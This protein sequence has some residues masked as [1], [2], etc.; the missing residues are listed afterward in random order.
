MSITD[1][2]RICV[3]FYSFVCWMISSSGLS[4]QVTSL[5]IKFF[6][7]ETISQLFI[8]RPQLIT[9]PALDMCSQL[10]NYWVEKLNQTI[11]DFLDQTS[12]PDTVMV[13]VDY[14]KPP[15]YDYRFHFDSKIDPREV[16]EVRKYLKNKFVCYSFQL[17]PQY[18]I[19]LDYHRITN[20][21]SEPILWT[22]HINPRN[23]VGYKTAFWYIFMHSSTELANYQEGNNFI[24]VYWPTISKINK[25][26]LIPVNR[27][28]ALSYKLYQSELLPP[29][30]NTKCYNYKS[31]QSKFDSQAHCFETCYNET[32]YSVFNL[33]SS[34]IPT[35]EP[36]HHK[37]FLLWKPEY[38]LH[39]KNCSIKCPRTDCIKND[40]IPTIVSLGKSFRPQFKLYATN[41]PTIRQRTVSKID[42]T[43]Y[44]IFVLSCINFWLG[45]S[46]LEFLLKVKSFK[47]NNKTNCVNGNNNNLFQ[48]STNCSRGMNQKIQFR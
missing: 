16:I 44:I 24:E 29:P 15:N 4:Y 37:R 1:K 46:P 40:F 17:K 21:F 10:R 23:F 27:I 32:I 3:L 14:R 7:Y 38:R 36:T 45:L 47:K 31:N 34:T 5:S 12:P 9:P 30:F 26:V 41:T 48:Q 11:K 35:F 8:A 2:K 18:A 25:T 43:E 39:E 33:V 6:K 22:I 28:I 20:D 19:K 13:A 42:L